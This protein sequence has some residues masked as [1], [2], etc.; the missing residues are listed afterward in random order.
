MSENVDNTTDHSNLRRMSWDE[1][2]FNLIKLKENF[3]KWKELRI[4]SFRRLIIAAIICIFSLGISVYLFTTDEKSL[5]SIIQIGSTSVFGAGSIGALVEYNDLKSKR[6]TMT[7]SKNEL[8]TEIMK[9][10]QNDFNMYGIEKSLAELDKYSNE[11]KVEGSSNENKIEESS[12][13]E[14]VKLK[15]DDNSKQI[16]NF[17]EIFGKIKENLKGIDGNEDDTMNYLIKMN[18]IEMYVKSVLMEIVSTVEII[19]KDDNSI[20]NDIEKNIDE[21]KTNLISAKDAIVMDIYFK[22][23]IDLFEKFFS[24]QCIQWKDIPLLILTALF[25]INLIL[26]GR[27]PIN[28][29]FKRCESEEKFLLKRFF[30]GRFILKR[31]EINSEEKNIMERLLFELSIITGEKFEYDV[32]KLITLRTTRRHGELK[33]HG[34]CGQD[35]IF[36]YKNQTI[37]I[38][39]KYR[40]CPK[41]K[42]SQT[43]CIYYYASENYDKMDTHV[44]NFEKVLRDYWNNDTGT[45][46]VVNDE[47]KIS[48]E[49]KNKKQ[50]KAFKLANFSSV[51][52]EIESCKTLNNLD[53]A[54]ITSKNTEFKNNESRN[55]IDNQIIK[56]VIESIETYNMKILNDD[57]VNSLS[58]LLKN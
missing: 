10:D 4:S 39:C 46:F 47:T 9:I 22:S 38:Q 44:C 41:C 13:E 8:I 49:Y 31:I 27:I 36:R 29:L 14:L 43:K 12:R 26:I 19:S 35:I 32:F 23:K 28:K 11:N 51:L 18:A 34:D 21:L 17:Q 48:S 54:S 3:E 2:K 50:K 57:F 40:Q 1:R 20:L 58:K 37:I 15:I 33:F 42:I 16:V 53:S 25:F 30:K 56:D 6:P 52:K 55:Q 24:E 45:I 7:I 5:G